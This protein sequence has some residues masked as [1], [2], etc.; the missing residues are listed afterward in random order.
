VVVLK[1]GI[2]P[3]TELIDVKCACGATYK[4][5]STRKEMRLDLCSACHPFFTG[6]RTIV[7]TA[8][9]VEKFERRAARAAKSKKE[10]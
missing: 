4:V 10:K 3:K 5:L 6:K 1:P 8:G 7:D 2:H 9:R